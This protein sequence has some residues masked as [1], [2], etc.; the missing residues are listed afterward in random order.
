MI[1]HRQRG[2]LTDDQIVHLT[3][4]QNIA[5]FNVDSITTTAS[6]DAHTLTSD[7][8]IAF[9]DD[10]E[11]SGIVVL[12]SQKR[13]LEKSVDLD[14][15]DH[16]A[17][18]LDADVVNVFTC[19][20]Q[21]KE[22]LDQLMRSGGIEQLSKQMNE[23]LFPPL[24]APTVAA[25]ISPGLEPVLPQV[26][27]DATSTRSPQTSA[28]L[29]PQTDS[30]TIKPTT[31][32]QNATASKREN[33]IILPHLSSS[34]MSNLGHLDSTSIP[35]SGHVPPQPTLYNRSA[36][37][38]DVEKNWS[39]L[40]QT[41]PRCSPPSA[42]PNV[43]LKPPQ[44]PLTPEPMS[45]VRPAPEPLASRGTSERRLLTMSPLHVPPYPSNSNN[46]SPEVTSPLYEHPNRRRSHA[47]V[48]TSDSK[49]NPRRATENVP[50]HAQRTST[51][52]VTFSPQGGWIHDASPRSSPAR[53]V[54]TPSSQSVMDSEMPTSQRTPP[55]SSSPSTGRRV[56]MSALR[57]PSSRFPSNSSAQEE[58]RRMVNAP[59]GVD[60]RA[61]F[62]SDIARPSESRI[63][64]TAALASRLSL[65]SG[66]VHGMECRMPTSEVRENL[67]KVS[68]L[69]V[70]SPM[71]GPSTPETDEIGLLGEYFVCF[72]VIP[73]TTK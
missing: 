65:T 18:M 32:A 70:T 5:F 25:Q 55:A 57:D 10:E 33:E 20:S 38:Q 51:D 16:L 45:R 49:I 46:A 43:I 67:Q 41:L 54:T 42:A 37:I 6:L 68:G 59:G 39:A 1:S 64:E 73:A 63:K 66:T 2:I 34:A 47:R 7:E 50:I 22:V 17:R 24:V 62:S 4:M 60:A 13:L 36:C 11:S 23:A 28:N 40:S 14:V 48:D 19:V 27:P 56:S 21:E 9:E 44:I 69:E 3:R 26:K 71:G 30:V 52:E 53:D 8:G 72:F 61:V 58:L 12:V 35:P 15:C 31:H 29:K